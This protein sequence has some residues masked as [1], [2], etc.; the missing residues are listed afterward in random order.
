MPFQ[1][2]WDI[3]SLATTYQRGLRNQ[4]GAWL[5]IGSSSL[6]ALGLALSLPIA[7]RAAEMRWRVEVLPTMT[8]GGAFSPRKPS[9]AGGMVVTAAALPL[10]LHSLLKSRSD[11]D[12]APGCQLIST[13]RRTRWKRLTTCYFSMLCCLHFCLAWNKEIEFSEDKHCRYQNSG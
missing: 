2:K 3:F 10:R 12:L 11:D 5:L 4:E 1:M 9:A 13:R 8:R 6:A 7:R